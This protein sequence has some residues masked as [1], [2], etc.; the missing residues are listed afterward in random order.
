MSMTPSPQN[1]PS[2]QVRFDLNLPL[3]G[4]ISAAA[5]GF[6]CF[7][8]LYFN[9]QAL[10]EAVKELQITV[11]SGNTSV[12]VLSSEVALIKFRVGTLE[13]DALRINEAIRNQKGQK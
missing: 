2:A 5:A 9:V 13:T 1:P 8:G 12:S 3:W 6:M 10:T 11:K 4:L 7:A